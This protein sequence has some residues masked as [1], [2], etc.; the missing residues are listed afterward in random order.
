MF[1]NTDFA[2]LLI[3]SAFCHGTEKQFSNQ[4]SKPEGV[5]LVMKLLIQVDLEQS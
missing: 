4:L 2:R 5:L 1:E 3:W